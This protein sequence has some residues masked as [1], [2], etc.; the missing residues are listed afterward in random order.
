MRQERLEQHNEEYRLREQQG[1][2]PLPA[3]VNLLSDEE[4]ESDGGTDHLQRVGTRAPI[5]TGRGGSLELVPEAGAEPPVVGLLKEVPAG[6]PEAPAGA[7]EVPP[8]PQG[9]G[10]RDSPI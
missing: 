6:A 3:L 5:A 8:S 2:S 1:V 7:A 10:S 9:R 4:E